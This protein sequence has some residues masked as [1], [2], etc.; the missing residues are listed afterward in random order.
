MQSPDISF[1]IELP[2]SDEK[3]RTYL[4]SAT[5]TTEDMNKQVV[6]LLL[7]NSFQ[8]TSG[9]DESGGFA[10]TNTFEL[11]SNQ[12]SSWL[13]Q[14]SDDVDVNVH[15]RP[16]TETTGQEVD[17]GLTTDILN[18]RLTVTT[19]V[20][21]KDQTLNPNPNA[22][23]NNIVGDFILEYK[24]TKDGRIRLK[25]FNK[26]NDNLNTSIYK[27]AAYTQ[28][29]GIVFRKDFDSNLR[30][31]PSDKEKLQKKY[32]EDKIKK[33]DIPESP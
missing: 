32:E 24:L 33:E 22:N 2:D 28:G 29:F 8:S 31:K 25:G 18:E 21:F 6:S 27:Q 30:R 9:W 4:R 26:S 12:V 19:Q 20:G 16:Q 15:Y 1:D 11:L 23:A 13:S 17:L 5:S 7:F 3:E 10:S 14:I